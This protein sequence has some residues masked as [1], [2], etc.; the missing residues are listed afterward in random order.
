MRVP[1]HIVEKRRERLR[2]LIR[3]DG[4]LPIAD[5]CRR[6]DVSEATA[7]RDLASIAAHGQI[8]RTRGGALADYNTSFASLGQRAHRARTAKTRIAAIA[9]AQIQDRTVILLDAGTTVQ[10]IARL[11]L[12]RQPFANLTVVTNSLPVASVL[13]GAAGIELHVLGGMFLHRQAVL[14]G[15][16]SVRAL[17]AWK[18]DAAFL[19]G[20]GMN[21]SGITN[22][23]ANIAAFQQAVIRHTAKTF[24]CLDATKLGRTTP[25]S[26]IGWDVPAT[27]ITDATPSAL[28]KASIP[29][30]L[31]RYLSA[32]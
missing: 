4:F 19:S 31:T 8:T 16:Q 25:H 15:P 14:L 1:L 23:H 30:P 28:A 9:L 20:E 26:V 7:R 18:F 5:I 12:G 17:A 21:A 11:L 24:F 32:K 13:G 10:S 3:T 29:L 22:S 27:L 2:Q 6:L